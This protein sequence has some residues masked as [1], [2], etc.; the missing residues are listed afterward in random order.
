VPL[1][2][3]IIETPSA[4][5]PE[6]FPEIDF[7][8]AGGVPKTSILKSAVTSFLFPAE[9]FTVKEFAPISATE[10]IPDKLP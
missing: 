2:E 5:S 8:P 4:T 7:V 10:D 3:I 6:T 9:T 1:P